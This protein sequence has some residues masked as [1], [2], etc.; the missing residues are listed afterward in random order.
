MTETASPPVSP[1]LFEILLSLS[2]GPMHG[3]RIIRDIEERTSGRVSLSTSTLYGGIRQL[4]RDGLV[5]DAGSRPDEGSGGPPRRY[6]RITEHGLGV[7]REETLRLRDVA[8]IASERLLGPG[9][10]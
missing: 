7:A 1:H 2:G 4:L 6:Y 9:A 10:E 5:A 8:R 3:Y